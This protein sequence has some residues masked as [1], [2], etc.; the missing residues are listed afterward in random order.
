MSH[1]PLPQD[2]GSTSVRTPAGLAVLVLLTDRWWHRPGHFGGSLSPVR[3]THRH[4]DE[5]GQQGQ[6]G[7]T[8]SHEAL[9]LIRLSVMTA[10]TTVDYFLHDSKNCAVLHCPQYQCS[11]QQLGIKC[12]LLGAVR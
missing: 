5:Q 7:C 3:Q 9:L 1:G 11:P 2:F 4:T 8:K 10:H 12:G 6:R